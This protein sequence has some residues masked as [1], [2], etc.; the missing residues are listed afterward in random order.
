MAESQGEINMSREEII[1]EIC[2]IENDNPRM[3]DDWTVEELQELYI[4]LKGLPCM[5]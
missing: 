2:E 1:A 5:E 3:Y 4:N